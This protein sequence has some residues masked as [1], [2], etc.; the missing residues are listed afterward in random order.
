VKIETLWI[1]RD[2]SK[3]ATLEDICFETKTSRLGRYVAGS[4]RDAWKTENHALYATREEAEVDARAR[5]EAAKNAPAEAPA[6]EGWNARIAALVNAPEFDPATN[7]ADAVHY[8][9]AYA[10]DQRYEQALY[11]AQELQ[12]T[13]NALVR[14]LVDDGI[15]A[16][17]EGTGFASDALQAVAALAALGA[18]KEA[19]STSLTARARVGRA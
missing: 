15:S 1:V 17:T 3:T 2:A 18:A 11:A 6:A 14:R 12:R 19:F 16:S 7:A 4:P 8:R 10:V 5:L 9:L 13:A